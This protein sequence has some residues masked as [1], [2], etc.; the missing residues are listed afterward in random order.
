M[1][2][3]SLWLFL[4][5]TACSSDPSRRAT[6]SLVDGGD[7]AGASSSSGGSVADGGSATGGRMPTGGIGGASTG[8][9]ATGGQGATG[10]AAGTGGNT[11][12]ASGI[13]GSSSGGVGGGATVAVNC[14]AINAASDTWCDHTGS[15]PYPFLC[16]AAPAGCIEQGSSGSGY[17]CCEGACAAMNQAVYSYLCTSTPTT[18]T[19]YVCSGD[20]ATL[21]ATLPGCVALADWPQRACCP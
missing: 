13:G 6:R 12:G 19:T 5:L 18:P 8:G 3:T 21:P 20:F 17:Y 14:E 4:F 16:R 2:R 7:T 15:Q 9:N 10:G 1:M 11:G